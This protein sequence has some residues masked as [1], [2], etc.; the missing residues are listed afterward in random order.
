[1]CRA[2]CDI[3]QTTTFLLMTE[4]NHRSELLARLQQHARKVKDDEQYCIDEAKTE[5]YLVEP[6]LEILGYDCR[7]PKAV[8]KRFIADVPGRK[9]DKVDYALMRDGKPAVLV[10]AKVLGNR[11][12]QEE[13]KQ[14]Q[15]YFP[16]TPAKLAV[17]T[18]G[19]RWHWYKGMSEQDQSHQM[20]STAF[21][22]YDA[23]EPSETAAEW[24]A[25]I[26]KDWFDHDELLRISRR[27]E[28]SHAVKDWIDRSLVNPTDATAG[29]LLKVAGI[30]VSSREIQLARDA[31]RI[32][33]AHVIADQKRCEGPGGPT[34]CGIVEPAKLRIDAESY[35]DASLDIGDGDPLTS[36]KIAR[37][38]RVAGGEWVVEK[39]AIRL[40]T[41][42]LGLLLEHDGRRNQE[43]ELA[44][45]HGLIVY[46]ETNPGGTYGKISG[47]SNLYYNKVLGN[48]AKIDLL[49][50][51]ASQLQ[52]DPPVNS[53]FLDDPVI[54]V[55]LVEGSPKKRSTARL[56]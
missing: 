46:S 54:E 4:I 14:L 20:E 28:I 35:I 30:R 41:T 49:K 37:A 55:W 3:L 50:S 34:R 2:C 25:R 15:G 22:T 32:A 42:V 10:E 9:G 12:G 31:I 23:S 17:L 13:I 1:M 33:W 16:H 48:R 47:F 5:T 45:I 29:Q 11:L 51:V 36:E 8:I 27:I 52:F 39:S 7:D 38:W 21:L 6:F 19:V 26:T 43:S 53:V 44:S 24:L 18:D 40:T 56:E